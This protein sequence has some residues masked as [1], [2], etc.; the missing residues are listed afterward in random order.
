MM[1][2]YDRALALKEEIKN[3]DYIQDGGWVGSAR[4]YRSTTQAIATNHGIYILEKNE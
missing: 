3:M 1:H 4:D 2:S